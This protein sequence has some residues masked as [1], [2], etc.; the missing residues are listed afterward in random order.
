MLAIA[1][2]M[3]R[4]VFLH[5]PTVTIK[6]FTKFYLFYLLFSHGTPV[7]VSNDI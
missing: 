4:L 3:R 2:R 7:L 1:I 5:S 6:V